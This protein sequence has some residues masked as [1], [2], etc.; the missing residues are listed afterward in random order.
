LYA[1]GFDPI[2]RTRDGPSWLT[3]TI[4]DDMLDAMRLR[5]SLLEEAGGPLQRF[6]LKRVM[7]NR[8]ARGLIRLS[9]ERYQPKD[10]LEHQQKV[11]RAGLAS[12]PRCPRWA[13][14]A[15]RQ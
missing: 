13:S 7:G 10:V 9:R 3:E 1:I 12:S 14:S 2:L 5:E 6:A 8:D 4:P 11:A 15:A